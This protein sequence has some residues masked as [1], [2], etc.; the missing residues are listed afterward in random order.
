MKSLGNRRERR[1]GAQEVLKRSFDLMLSGTGL[2]LSSPVWLTV[3]AAIVAEDGGPV[4]FCQDRWGKG[5]KTFHALKFRTMWK[6]SEKTRSVQAGH[7]DARITKVGRFLRACALD[8]L[9]QL[10]NIFRGDMSFVGPRA[11][12]INE[13]Q[14]SARGKD[15]PDEAVR[16]FRDRLT[17]RPGLT[18]IA[19]IFADR[20]TTRERKFR[21]DLFYIRRQDF[22]LDLRLIIL[23]FYIS[24]LGR[25]EVRGG[26]LNRRGAGS[27]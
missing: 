8:E 12:P 19:Q 16:G 4:F 27:V 15:V 5:G 21:Y 20:D 23:S 11:L 22:W 1:S 3:A 17:V 2:I 9:P 7:Q 6:G 13:I 10:W 26:K 14:A 24:F 25:W 18:G